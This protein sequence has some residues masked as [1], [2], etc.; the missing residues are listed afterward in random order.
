MEAD[1]AEGCIYVAKR[2]VG[3]PPA[4]SLPEASGRKR[5]REAAELLRREDEIL[6]LSPKEVN[7]AR[8]LFYE[9]T[10]QLHSTLPI[11]DEVAAASPSD[12]GQPSLDQIVD[13]IV[14]TRVAG[15]HP[16][17]FMPP[18]LA[19]IDTIPVDTLRSM[20]RR[21]MRFSMA[22]C[23]FQTRLFV[24]PKV[25]EEDMAM[26]HR[27]MLL[28]SVASVSRANA[29][30]CGSD[31]SRRGDRMVLENRTA[32]AETEMRLLVQHLLLG[33][34]S[35]AVGYGLF[36]VCFYFILVDMTVARM[37][38]SMAVQ[39]TVEMAAVLQ[40]SDEPAPDGVLQELVHIREGAYMALIGMFT[41]PGT[42]TRFTMRNLANL[43]V[44]MEP[45]MDER[46]HSYSR[47][48]VSHHQSR[49]KIAHLI[50]AQ[51][52][53]RKSMD[54]ADLSMPPEEARQSLERVMVFV[55]MSHTH[56]ASLS[57]AA[58]SEAGS[59]VFGLAIMNATQW[60]LKGV[61]EAHAGL[62]HEARKSA[63]LVYHSCIVHMAED[64]TMEPFSVE[65]LHFCICIFCRVDECLPLARICVAHMKTIGEV[66]APFRSVAEF[67]GRLFE[68]AVKRALGKP[69]A[70][71]PAQR[72]ADVSAPRASVMM[73]TDETF[74]QSFT[75]D[76]R[77]SSTTVAS[78][79]TESSSTSSYI[80]PMLPVGTDSSSGM[81]YTSTPETPEDIGAGTSTAPAA[82]QPVPAA[83]APPT[84]F[85]PAF[86][87]ELPSLNAWETLMQENGPSVLDYWGESVLAKSAFDVDDDA[88][89]F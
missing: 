86:D 2:R 87:S 58:T 6:D 49:A 61:Y 14:K 55:E 63:E 38:A 64:L 66:L 27:M 8:D 78:T 54:L 57:V 44:D 42:T 15:L 53:E 12:G 72:P 88:L 9:V 11:K 37:Y 5:A 59:Q 50:R 16:R 26:F 52:R 18:G 46:L 34:P 35:L 74:D 31:E 73:S 4:T 39:M 40:D 17:P 3:R 45:L 70:G 13:D 60:M 20:V 85:T 47:M 48:T 32:A 51:Y 62:L 84:A 7:A 33:G 28:S 56:L 76:L 10:A 43:F 22:T 83:V 81:S 80:S 19:N 1:A 25:T 82:P 23:F 65:L 36:F 77:G 89:H 69:T 29:A 24:D 30:A 67:D 68:A 41:S 79:H 21:Y 71:K 75:F